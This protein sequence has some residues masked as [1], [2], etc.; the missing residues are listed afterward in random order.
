[1]DARTSASSFATIGSMRATCPLRAA[2]AIRSTV[3]PEYWNSPFSELGLM[4]VRVSV[5]V[6]GEFTTS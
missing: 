6:P 5:R 4:I 3:P 2:S 1:V